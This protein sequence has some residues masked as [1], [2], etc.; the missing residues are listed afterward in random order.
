MKHSSTASDK[1]IS[2]GDKTCCAGDDRHKKRGLKVLLVDDDIDILEVIGLFLEMDGA[3]VSYA[4]DYYKALDIFEKENFDIVITDW[5]MPRMHGLFLLDMVK[6]AKPE[7]PVIVITAF[8]SEAIRD[9]AQKKQVD[10]MLEKPFD[11]KDLH[12]AILK[13]VRKKDVEKKVV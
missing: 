11:Y 2:H 1:I 10:M 8:L 9:E 5:R 12:A 3:H 4:H 6:S 7:M 13:L